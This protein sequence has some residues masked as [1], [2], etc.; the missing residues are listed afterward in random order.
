MDEGFREAVLRVVRAVPAGRVTT[1]GEVALLAGRPN[2]ARQVGAILYGLR[3]GE[4]DDV[5]W[6]RVINASG[7]ISTYKVG[8]GELQ[9]ALLR[10]EGVEVSD[11]RVDLR[12]YR[13]L[14][15]VE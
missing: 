2:H 12:R 7:G 10:S 1:Y 3:G 4:V 6:Q 8:S 5:P 13:W 11:D 14:G 9:V 15:D